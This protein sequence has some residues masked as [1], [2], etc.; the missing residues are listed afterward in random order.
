[1]AF[2][3]NYIFAIQQSL[4][5]LAIQDEVR[6][7]FVAIRCHSL[8]NVNAMAFSKKAK[9]PLQSLVEVFFIRA[10]FPTSAAA[11]LDTAEQRRLYVRTAKT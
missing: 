4:I 11:T 5:A 1:M 7:P 6:M 3:D 2:N 9:R 10:H 8:S